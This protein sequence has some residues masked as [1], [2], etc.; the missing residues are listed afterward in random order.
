M[1]FIAAVLVREYSGN[2]IKGAKDMSKISKNR[3]EWNKLIKDFKRR[4]KYDEKRGYK[5]SDSLI[6]KSPA[7]VTKKSIQQLKQSMTVEQRRERA[8]V[9]PIA[10]QRKEP[11]ISGAPNALY[12]L[13]MLV[14]ELTSFE[15]WTDVNKYAQELQ[16]S[17]SASLADLLIERMNT[18]DVVEVAESI[19][20]NIERIHE[21]L[22]SRFRSSKSDE[23]VMAYQEMRILILGRPMTLSETMQ[24]GLYTDM[25]DIN[26]EIEDQLNY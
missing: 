17:Y 12:R 3:R 13:N 26:S 25:L 21:I 20:N 8:V 7:R 4:L 15:A 6:P 18:E 23:I 19:D 5:Y 11:Y 14:E 22:Q 9:R 10:K 16:N 24:T 2:I 1:F